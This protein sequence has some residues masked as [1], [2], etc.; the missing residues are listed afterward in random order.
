M[1]IFDYDE[2]IRYHKMMLSNRYTPEERVDL[3][4]QKIVD[5]Y[6]N[7]TSDDDF[8]EVKITTEVKK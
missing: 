5:N 2:E 6:L 7:R 1:N 3:A 4:H 8:A